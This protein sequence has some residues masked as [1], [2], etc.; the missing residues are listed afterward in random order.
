MSSD[1]TAAAATS[2]IGDASVAADFSSDVVTDKICPLNSLPQEIHSYI[3]SLEQRITAME[4]E[5]VAQKQ[6]LMD[7]GK[8]IYNNPMTKMF[9]SSAPKDIQAR[10]KEFF[11]G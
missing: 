2:S 8:F 11:G 6:R 10:L 5:Q 1:L 3:H 9:L 4:T 7:A